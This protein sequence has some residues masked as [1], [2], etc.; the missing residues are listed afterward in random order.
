MMLRIFE[1][2]ESKKKEKLLCGG[3]FLLGVIA[4]ASSRIPEILFPAG[5]QMVGAVSLVLS[6]M[7]VAGCLVRRYVYRIE[8]E[9]DSK[10]GTPDLTV[11]EYMG[12]RVRVVCRVSLDEVADVERIT[13]EN[14]ERIVKEMKGHPKFNYTG[15]LF[16][17]SMWLVRLKGS[18][19]YTYLQILANQDFIDAL[20]DR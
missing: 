9:D 16:S 6:A 18:G 12:K 14:K 1:P 17:E 13:R 5:L 8:V 7:I 11:I 10:M 20:Q 2:Q 4:T 3:A 19:E 15:V